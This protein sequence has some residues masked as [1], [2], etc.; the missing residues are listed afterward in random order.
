MTS[1]WRIAVLGLL[2]VGIAGCSRSPQHA[3]LP[4]QIL[5][6]SRP[7]WEM[8]Q[9]I[10]P[11]P[12]LPP[13]VENEPVML[14]TSV[15]SGTKSETETTHP[16]HSRHHAKSA[17]QEA[18]QPEAAK[19]PATPAAPAQ[20]ASGPPSDSSPIGE[21][22]TAS[23]DTNTADRQTVLDQIN[24]TENSLNGIHRSLSS[25]E[26]KTAA[27]IRTFVGKA[28]QALKTDD[29]DGARNFCTKA[30]ILLKELT[31]Q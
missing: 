23:P 31:Q 14:D 24:A 29:L 10:P 28:R 9:L 26:Q 7:P 3:V 17:E 20:E 2:S 16:S 30:K 5:A 27:L 11:M 15:P 12:Q 6:P 13:W 22:S 18:A 25:D 21:L 8:A 4:P 19:N 1:G